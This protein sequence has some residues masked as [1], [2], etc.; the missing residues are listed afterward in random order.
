[1]ARVAA[2]HILLAR[3]TCKAVVARLRAA[4]HTREPV[5]EAAVMV[6]S[7]TTGRVS[8]TKPVPEALGVTLVAGV[9]AVTV[10]IQTAAQQQLVPQVP[11]ALAVVAAAH[12]TVVITSQAAVVA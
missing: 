7:V 2:T 1:M 4:D 6:D 8:L 9:M 5:A 11:E 10:M 12:S 3:R